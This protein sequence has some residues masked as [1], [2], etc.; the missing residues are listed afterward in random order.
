LF[1][2]PIAELATSFIRLDT[3]QSDLSLSYKRIGDVRVAQRQAPKN[4]LE[5]DKMEDFQK[6]LQRTRTCPDKTKSN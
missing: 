6:Q 5:A 2:R 4:P 1:G 3:W